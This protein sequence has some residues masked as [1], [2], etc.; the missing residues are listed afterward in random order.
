MLG[1]R[2]DARSVMVVALMLIV[3]VAVMFGIDMING[4]WDQPLIQPPL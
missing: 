2:L 3:I 4:R 1:L